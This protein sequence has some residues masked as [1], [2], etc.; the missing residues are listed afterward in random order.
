MRSLI[1]ARM[2]ST[3]AA[4]MPEVGSSTSVRRAAPTEGGRRRRAASGGPPGAGVPRRQ[5]VGGD[6]QMEVDVEAQVRAE[7]LDD[8]DDAAG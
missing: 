8:R 3:S 7:A 1:P 4:R 5:E 2:R 6:E